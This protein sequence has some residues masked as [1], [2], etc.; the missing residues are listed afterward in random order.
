V[1]YQPSQTTSRRSFPGAGLYRC[2][3]L[4]FLAIAIYGSLIP[5]DYRPLPFEEAL[6]RFRTVCDRPL[7]VDSSPDFLANIA[8]FVPLGFFL[9]AALCVDGSRGI[10]LLAALVV[11]P[12][13]IAA[14]ATIEFSQLYFP[15]RVSSLNDITAESLGALIGVLLWLALGQRVTN[16][17]RSVGA[18]RDNSSLSARLL[19]GYIVLL[20]LVNVFPF[21]LTL[22]PV[23]LYHKYRGGMVRLVPFVSRTEDLYHLLQKDLWSVALFLPVGL[24][25]ARRPNPQW[26]S[27]WGLFRAL[28]FGL[29]LAA[30]I[31]V[32][33]FFVAS[34]YS[35]ATDLVTETLGVLLGWTIGRLSTPPSSEKYEVRSIKYESRTSAFVLRASYFGLLLVWLGVLVFFAWEPFTFSWDRDFL[36]ERYLQL[37]WLPFDDYVANKYWHSFDQ[38]VHKTLMYLP[39]GALWT[40]CLMPR[41]WRWVLPVVLSAGVAVFLEVGQF[42]LPPRYPSVTDVL[43]QFLGA[44]MGCAL[45]GRF[46]RAPAVLEGGAREFCR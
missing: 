17:A 28:A 46:L 24:L 37:K 42:F 33:Q 21:D 13:C 27:V 23:A 15:S 25:L 26:R 35:D 7:G 14:S 5:F 38:F 45:M 31:E 29:G 34:R 18:A 1:S 22:S 19:P 32:L 12:F 39:L 20:I 10:S 16:W 44:C 36:K 9:M 40:L 6:A 2:L 11:M 8:L 43:I 30:F 3:A 41:G 4:L